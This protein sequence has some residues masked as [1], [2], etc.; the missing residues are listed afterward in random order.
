MI[1]KPRKKQRKLREDEMRIIHIGRD[2]IAELLWENLMEHQDIYFDVDM[3]D[4]SQICQMCWSADGGTL[5]YAVLPVC[6]AMEGKKLD[7]DALG[8]RIGLTTASLF[9]PC[10]YR[11]V[12]ITPSAFLMEEEGT[13]HSR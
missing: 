3:V 10:R 9:S 6:Y 13:A 11:T 4:D 2:A 8:K 12:K 1:V 5:T 7:M